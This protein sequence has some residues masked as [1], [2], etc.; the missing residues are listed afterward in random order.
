M[1][2]F[3][4]LGQ[5]AR[6][7]PTLMLTKHWLDATLISKRGRG[8][9]SKNY[10]E[11]K[12]LYED[13]ANFEANDLILWTSSRN[14]R[15]PADEFRVRY[16][17]ASAVKP[18]FLKCR[19]CRQDIDVSFEWVEMHD[20]ANETVFDFDCPHCWSVSTYTQP[21]V[22][23][24]IVAFRKRCWKWIKPASRRPGRVGPAIRFRVLERDG[25][26]CS[27]CGATPGNTSLHVD[28]VVP[29]VEGGTNDFENLRTACA[30]CNLGKGK[31][32]VEA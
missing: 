7:S 21:T 24:K 19:E 20:T 31:G 11:Y 14:G 26:R 3:N 27:Y 16:P 12:F 2:A 22:V 4:D 15:L 29:L 17:P 23:A 18:L 1:C 8:K 28:H 9:M 6:G 5:A 13:S 30:E 32:S 10:S 25:F